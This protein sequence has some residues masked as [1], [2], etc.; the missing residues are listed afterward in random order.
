MPST[1]TSRESQHLSVVPTKD[2]G[3]PGALTRAQVA[4]RLG[5]SVSTVRRYEGERLHPRI[6]EDDV[7]WFDPKEVAALAA[8]LTD[9]PRTIRRRNAEPS[10]SA[11]SEARSAGEIAAQV[12]ERLEQRQSLAEI[13]IGVRVEP[14]LV[15]ALYEQWCLGLVEAHLQREREPRVYRDNEIEHINCEQLANR[16][17]ALPAGEATRISVGRYRGQY[18]HGD[19]VYPEVVELGG[20]LVAGPCGFDE[21][22]RR[23]G[24]GDYRITAYGFDA[25]GLRWECIVSGVRSSGATT[26]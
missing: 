9:E 7:R 20:F 15:R 26:L 5:V 10:P 2:A 16:L 14:D 12:F 8:T 1:A 18:Q 13:V 11:R 24:R 19:F 4:T 22:V 17:A 23:F 3:N 25:P 6:D 21:I